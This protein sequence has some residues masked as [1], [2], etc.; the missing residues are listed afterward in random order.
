MPRVKRALRDLSWYSFKSRA[1]NG[2]MGIYWQGRWE[3]NKTNTGQSEVG[4]GEKAELVEIRSE[5]G[6]SVPPRCF[7]SGKWKG[8]PN[9]GWMLVIGWLIKA[10]AASQ[11]LNR[12]GLCLAIGKVSFYIGFMGKGEKAEEEMKKRHNWYSATEHL[13]LTPIQLNTTQKIRHS[14]DWKEE[15]FSSQTFISENITLNTELLGRWI[16][17]L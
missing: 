15:A 7:I 10:G 9:V 13:P 3:L 4:V 12:W 2:S 5:G 1:K 8:S 16:Q 17:R 6:I 14:C 11:V